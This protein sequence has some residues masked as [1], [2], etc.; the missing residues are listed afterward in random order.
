MFILPYS[1]LRFPA[2]EPYKKLKLSYHQVA[3]FTR[4]ASARQRALWS[5]GLAGIVVGLLGSLG[6]YRAYKAG[7]PSATLVTI[8]EE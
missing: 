7:A 3:L 2:C 1:V 5:Y 4:E 6:T 8:D